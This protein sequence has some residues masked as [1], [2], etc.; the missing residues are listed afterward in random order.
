MPQGCSV[1]SSGPP[2]NTKVAR[3]TAV[4][5]IETISGWTGF[6]S[7]PHVSNLHKHATAGRRISR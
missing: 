3:L 6:A 2:R 1:L 7:L 4:R 5:P